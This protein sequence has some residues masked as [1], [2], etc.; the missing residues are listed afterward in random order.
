MA[1][2]Y[3]H[4]RLGLLADR[5]DHLGSTEE[6]QPSPPPGRPAWGVVQLV[7]V[8]VLVMLASLQWVVGVLAYDQWEGYGLRPGWAVVVAAWLLVSSAPGRATIVVAARRGLLRGL[9][10]GALPRQG[11]LACRLWF[12]E[13]LAQVFHLDVLAGTPWTARYA[14]MTGA[15]VGEGDEPEDT[16]A[17]HQPAPHRRRAS[18]EADVDVHGWW[19]E[20]PDIV[21]GEIHIG[22]GAAGR[23]P[24]RP[25]ARG[26]HRGRGRGRSGQ[27]CQRDGTSGRALVGRHRHAGRAAPVRGGPVA[28]GGPGALAPSGRAGPAGAGA[29]GAL[30]PG[31]HGAQR[32]ADTGR[33]PRDRGAGHAREPGLA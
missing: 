4:R 28:P 10:P 5:L 31:H 26:G 13:R 20:G 18:L 17:A 25:H 11:W 21:V 6:R 2:V 8:L 14:R 15:D 9:R 30:R 24:D 19:V 1:D 29:E 23:R 22:E 3:H 16:A 7:G 32:F 12:V 27:R 33:R